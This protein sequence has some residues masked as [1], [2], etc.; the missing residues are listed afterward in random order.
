M[1]KTMVDIIILSLGILL[2]IFTIFIAY[3]WY[4]VQSGIEKL[5]EIRFMIIMESF[6]LLGKK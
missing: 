1:A 5:D 3:F 4:Y 6:K 2:L